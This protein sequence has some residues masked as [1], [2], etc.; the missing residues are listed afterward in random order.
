MAELLDCQIRVKG[1][2]SSQWTGWFDGLEIKNQPNGEAL[3]S[4]YLPDQAAL[5][6]VLKRTSNLGL[7]LISLN[8]TER[9]PDETSVQPPRSDRQAELGWR[10]R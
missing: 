2:L 7:A 5:Y 3:I 8:C 6:G 1:H 4:G 10:K 9:S